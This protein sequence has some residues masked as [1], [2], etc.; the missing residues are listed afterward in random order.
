MNQKFPDF[1]IFCIGAVLCLTG[2]AGQSASNAVMQATP[3]A[4]PRATPATPKQREMERHLP[5]VTYLPTLPPTTRALPTVTPEDTHIMAETPLPFVHEVVTPT[6]LELYI[7]PTQTLMPVKLS[8]S[9][10]TTYENGGKNRIHNIRRA[11]EA[12]NGAE[13]APGGEFSYNDAVGPTTKANGYKKARI[14]VRG[15]DA[16]GY[17]GGVCQVSSTLYNAAESA[18]LTVLERHPHSK[19]VT[20]VAKDRDAATSFGGIDLR[21]SNPYP[22]AVRI[23]AEGTDTMVTVTVE[24]M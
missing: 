10:A 1:R 16:E 2:C 18:G 8:A 5:I 11:A 14:F 6:P 24:E 22:F 23:K 9:F 19:A 15:K 7:L 13:I 3:R 21:L 20:Y 12:I 17:G 4:I